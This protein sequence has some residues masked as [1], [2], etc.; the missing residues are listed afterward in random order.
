[1]LYKGLMKMLPR[2]WK[3]FRMAKDFYKCEYIINGMQLFVVP[4]CAGFRLN[5]AVLRPFPQPES[6]HKSLVSGF[7]F[8]ITLF[9]QAYIHV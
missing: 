1:M 2:G 9:V 7:K 5:S 6:R 3:M 4:A 8:I